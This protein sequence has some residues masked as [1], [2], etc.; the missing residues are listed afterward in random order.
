[1]S[2]PQSLT[3]FHADFGKEFPFRILW[4]GPSQN[5]SP[6]SAVCP[7]L[8]RTEHFGGRKVRKCAEERGGRGVANKGGR[9]EK[10]TRENRSGLLWLLLAH[11][12]SVF[13]TAASSA[14]FNCSL[15]FTIASVSSPMLDR[16]YTTDEEGF[17]RYGYLPRESDAD[18]AKTLPA[19][20]EGKGK[21]KEKD[22]EAGKALEALQLQ[23]LTL[24]SS[25]EDPDNGAD[26]GVVAD[27]DTA[28]DMDPT[29]PPSST[30]SQPQSSSKKTPCVVEAVSSAEGGVELAPL[31]KAN[32]LRRSVLRQL[33]W[34]HGGFAPFP[35]EPCY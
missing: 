27:T 25:Q 9:K 15:S 30:T 20:E 21:E 19:K 4:R 18:V 2:N 1:M 33:S 6:S 26:F 14:S 22:Q 16:K 3:F 29:L 11:L 28:P 17:K 31:P 12:P 35:F 24:E 32:G 7:L 13:T 10:R 5:P 23:S 34:C 8:Y